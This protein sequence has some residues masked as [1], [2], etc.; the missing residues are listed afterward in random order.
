M[1]PARQQAGVPFGVAT[2]NNRANSSG[3]PP[4]SNIGKTSQRF[5]NVVPAGASLPLSCSGRF[6]YLLNTS[7]PLQIRPRNGAFQEYNQG[8]G[9]EIEYEENA[10][11]LLEIKNNSSNPVAFEIFVG[12]DSFID[13][14]LIL[15]MS[16]TPFI[17]RPT[18]QE[19]SSAALVDIDDISGTSFTDINGG[20]WYALYRVAIIISNVDTGVTLL[21]QKADSVVSNGPAVAAIFPSTSIRYDASGDYRLHL[22][23]ANINALVSEIYA[24][25]PKLN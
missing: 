23:G 21:L 16:S 7:G 1:T 18:Y 15:S 3:R 4:V 13:K 14:R 12:W 2:N 6:F 17:V 19:A 8:T 9:L 22:G 11:D 24:S 5:T 25:I 10:F 20:E